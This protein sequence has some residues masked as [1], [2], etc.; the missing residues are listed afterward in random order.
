MNWIPRQ[1]NTERQK[2][3]AVQCFFC[4]Y[5]KICY[6]KIFNKF[7]NSQD[8]SNII[9]LHWLISTAIALVGLERKDIVGVKWCQ[10]AAVWLIIPDSI[11]QEGRQYFS[12]HL[13]IFLLILTSHI[14]SRELPIFFME[15]YCVLAFW[16]LTIEFI[17][18][19]TDCRFSSRWKLDEKNLI[20]SSLK[21]QI[22]SWKSFLFRMKNS[23]A[24]CRNFSSNY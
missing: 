3:K 2:E 13:N 24:A 18:R 7:K 22:W 12:W 10:R 19:P 6:C 16:R 21:K 23:C 8:V 20:F 11:F 15:A 5:S 17:T 14:I 9:F 4:V 1:F